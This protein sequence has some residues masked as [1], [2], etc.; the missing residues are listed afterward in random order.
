MFIAATEHGSFFV[1]LARRDPEDGLHSQREVA[2]ERCLRG[3]EELG[4]QG[5]FPV[6]YKFCLYI[7]H[8][9]KE[10]SSLHKVWFC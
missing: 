7:Q 2:V 6:S 10:F 1:D 4:F 8:I 3:G 9:F 5:L